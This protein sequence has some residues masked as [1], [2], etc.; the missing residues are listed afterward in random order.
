MGGVG[1][2]LGEQRDAPD[3]AL[4]IVRQ[5][6]PLA[7]PHFVMEGAA[8][9]LVF[10][11]L[12]GACEPPALRLV[13][14]CVGKG[15]DELVACRAVDRPVGGEGLV[16]L[17]DLL[18]EDGDVRS[19]GGA[20]ALQVAARIG[21]AVDMVDPKAVHRALPH[22]G[23]DEPV[24][25]LEDRGILDAQARK[26]GDLEEAAIAEMAARRLPVHQPPGLGRMHG[27]DPA[28]LARKG[29]K[30][31][32]QLLACAGRCQRPCEEARPL[33]VLLGPRR[34]DGACETAQHH[35]VAFRGERVE[36]FAVAERKCVVP[37]V[38][39]KAER[40]VRQLPGEILAEEGQGQ[41]LGPV[42]IEMAGK[43][44]FLAPDDHAAP[45]GVFEAR[46]HVVG[47]DVE[48]EADAVPVQVARK[49]AKAV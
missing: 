8:M 9:L 47:H 42:D 29:R 13:D 39:R 3:L 26:P 33:R 11:W 37:R 28:R 4:E 1:H 2:G 44:A 19:H 36:A 23:E 46:R 7:R 32:F 21:E 34:Q 45:P 38:E 48:D 6:L 15:G 10:Q 35:R 5:H 41:R 43:R 12:E 40:V 49:A 18:D 31:A 22:E 24:A 27:L 25:L 30:V 20:Q 14:E 17:Q 16:F